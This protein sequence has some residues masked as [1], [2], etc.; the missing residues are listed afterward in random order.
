MR[1]HSIRIF[2]VAVAAFAAVA[3]NNDINRS[4]SPVE[5]VATNTQILNRIDV[6]DTTNCN[7]N[8]GTIS[9]QAIE[10]NP[11]AG[12]TN[13]TFNQVRVTRYQVSYVRTDGGKQVP[14]SFVRS[15]D[16]LLTPGGAAQ[17][18]SSFIVLEPEAL[19]QAPFVALN[20]IN[21]GRDPDTGQTVVKM[22]VV[23]TL[24]GE[25]LA[26]TNVSANTRFPLD[27]CYNC[28]GCS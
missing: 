2:V 4:A 28:G 27:F 7:Q 24:F 16:T 21:G 11:D 25:T 12:S 18:L 14:A 15:I 17:G 19:L 6:F 3:C 13:T 26:G 8:I 1:N 10:K 5:L 23:V 9:M 20:P 22:D